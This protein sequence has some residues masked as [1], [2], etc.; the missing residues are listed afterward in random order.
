VAWCKPITIE[1]PALSCCKPLARGPYK[2]P[3]LSLTNWHDGTV[4][5]LD[6]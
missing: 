2:D 1:A 3:W 6:D 5:V 4:L